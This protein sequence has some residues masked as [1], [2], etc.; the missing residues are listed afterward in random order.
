MLLWFIDTTA[1]NSGQ[2][3]D[4]VS[5][6][7]LVL[8]SGKLALLRASGCRFKF[9]CEQS[10]AVGQLWQ[11]T[12][13]FLTRLHQCQSTP[14]SA[15]LSEKFNEASLDF[16]STKSWPRRWMKTRSKAIMSWHRSEENLIFSFFQEIELFRL[17]EGHFRFSLP[18]ETAFPVVLL[19]ERHQPA[20]E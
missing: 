6:T 13:I 18:V 8:S 9:H 4:N 20:T 11:V 1:G 19:S 7:H 12:T 14:A 5:P 10:I 16:Y 17:N 3:F 2:R 15:S